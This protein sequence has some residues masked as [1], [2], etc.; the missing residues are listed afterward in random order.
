MPVSE[1]GHIPGRDDSVSGSQHPQTIRLP[2]VLL[3]GLMRED[4][5]TR[6]LGE[7]S[8]TGTGHII[9]R[10]KGKVSTKGKCPKRN[11]S[12][13]ASG[14]QAGRWLDGRHGGAAGQ[15]KHRHSRVQARSVHTHQ[16]LLARGVGH[17]H[18]PHADTVVRL[19]TTV[20]HTRAHRAGGSR[21][22]GGNS[23]VF[24]VV[25][26]GVVWCGVVWCGMLYVVYSVLLQT[27]T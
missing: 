27:L 1:E 8:A 19:G 23:G 22:H 7:C 10:R 3:A 11:G 25:W 13:L 12:K 21:W 2:V 9:L 4:A 18:R 26:C 20:I 14:M 24:C 15:W 6:V 16:H 5:A 17:G